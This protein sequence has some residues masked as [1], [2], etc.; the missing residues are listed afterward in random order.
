MDV[1]WSSFFHG[2]TKS[3]STQAFR[4][5]SNENLNKYKP[6]RNIYNKLLGHA[7]KKIKSRSEIGKNLK[8]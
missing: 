5:P 2:K 8:N 1:K 6:Y 4:V 7:A 3:N